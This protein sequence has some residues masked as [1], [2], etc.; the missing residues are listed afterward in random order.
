MSYESL[1]YLFSNLSTY[2]L[3]NVLTHTLKGTMISAAMAQ[4]ALEYFLTERLRLNY[5]RR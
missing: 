5:L 4:T 1:G 2:T 3:I